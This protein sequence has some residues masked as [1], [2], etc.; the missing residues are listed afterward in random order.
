[1]SILSK[2]SLKPVDLARPVCPEG[3]ISSPTKEFE[4]RQIVDISTYTPYFLSAV[5]NALSR[6]ASQQYLKTFGVGI[7]EW[8]V[9]S[10]LAIEP[11]IPASRIC[12]VVCLDKAG[13]SRALKRLFEAGYLLFEASKTDPRRKIWW[14]STKGNE[15][16]DEILSIALKRERQLIQGV[17]PQ[18]LEVFLKV[19]RQMRKNVDQLES[20]D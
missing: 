19:I 14:L 6:G 4:G 8:R 1:M 9:T 3:R 18:E 13:T 20:G 12:D 11:K 15:L 5:N 7:V 2:E 10:M 17:D 16:H